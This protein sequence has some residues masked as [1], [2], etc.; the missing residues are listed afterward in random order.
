MQKARTYTDT[1]SVKS[2]SKWDDYRML[3]KVNL[4]LVV[5]ITSLLAY[6]IVAGSSITLIGV[7][8]LGLGGFLVTAAA[9]A[10]NQVL[11]KD[12]DK[13]MKRT[14][15]RPVTAGRMKMSEAVMF[16]GVSCLIGIVILSLFNPLT[17]L[18]GMLSF[19]MYAFV[20]TPLKRYS[21]LAV[22]VGAIPG[23]LPVLIGCTAFEGRITILAMSLFLVQFLW[24]FPHFW[25]IGFLGFDDY[26]EAGFKLL[27][28]RDEK[29]DRSLG[30]NSVIYS[31]LIIPIIAVLW[32]IGDV[33][34]YATAVAA[35]A[36]IVYTIFGVKFH[37][38]FDRKTARNLMFCSFFYMP[39]VLIG[40][41][42]F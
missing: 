34:I 25:A 27:P 7:V 14:E 28:V 32:K 35:V 30:I 17:G 4:S 42:I 6:A 3:V 1:I 39:V 13:L 21:T 26:K 38:A 20:Y 10:I 37:F 36:T 24:Q 22:A 18:L 19:V 33:S 9:N 5:V 2:F 12:F 31:L 29:I 40:Y 41:L 11:E 8:L 23:A 16:A 15:D